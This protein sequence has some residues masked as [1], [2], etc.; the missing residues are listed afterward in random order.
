MLY[1]SRIE[2]YNLIEENTHFEEWNRVEHS[3]TEHIGIK[4]QNLK[5]NRMQQNARTREWTRGKV[6]KN[7]AEHRRITG[8]NRIEY[9]TVEQNSRSGNRVGEPWSRT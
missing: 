9:N 8:H 7:E 1:N 6:S 3:G 2:E 5:Q 4:H